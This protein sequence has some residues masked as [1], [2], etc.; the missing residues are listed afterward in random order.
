MGEDRYLLEEGIAREIGGVSTGGQDDGTPSLDLAAGLV[1]VLVFDTDDSAVLLDEVGDAGL[2]DELDAVGLGDGEVLDG[3]HEGVGDGHAR[4]LFLA[5]VSSGEGVSS[6]T[7]DEREI[8]LE[9]I[10]EPLDGRCRATGEDLD[11]V[12]AEH[13]T[14]RSGGVIVECLDRVLD[15]KLW[16]LKE[17]V[18]RTT[19]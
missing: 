9:L 11:E 15:A 14:G 2:L 19:R 16:V 6:E 1:E 10:L 3:L 18:R 4:H 13:F 12:G 5:T 8:E 7:G 17:S